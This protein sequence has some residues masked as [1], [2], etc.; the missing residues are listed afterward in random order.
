MG[1]ATRPFG[2]S[3]SRPGRL[4]ALQRGAQWERGGSGQQA[5]MRWAQARVCVE[6]PHPPGEPAQVPTERPCSCSQG[7]RRPVS[8]AGQTGPQIGSPEPASLSAAASRRPLGLGSPHWGAVLGALPMGG[9][10]R[11]PEGTLRL[12]SRGRS[13]PPAQ[14]RGGGLPA[15]SHGVSSAPSPSHPPRGSQPP[16][17]GQGRPRGPSMAVGSSLGLHPAMPPK[18]GWS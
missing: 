17:A 8:V 15:R 1:V 16:K 14:N 5:R 7:N 18:Q 2:P 9:S 4:A 13:T 6:H 11:E 12:D 3:P 10:T